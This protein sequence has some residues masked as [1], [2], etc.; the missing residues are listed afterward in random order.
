MMSDD[1]KKLLTINNGSTGRKD[2]SGAPLPLCG[3]TEQTILEPNPN[4]EPIRQSPQEQCSDRLGEPTPFKSFP[5]GSLIETVRDPQRRDGFRLVAYKDQK[6]QVV[7]QFEHNGDRFV[8]GEIV[9]NLA[10]HLRLA[11]GISL[12]GTPRDLLA[13]LVATFRDFVDLPDGVLQIF[14]AFVL[15]TWFP[16]RLR[17]A[18]YL[19]LVGPL[20]SGKTTIEKLLQALCRRAFLVGDLTPASLYQLPGLLSPTLLI[21]ENDLGDSLTSDAIRRLLRVGNTPGTP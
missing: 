13:E 6:T 8:P 11:A 19:W 4:P 7:D 21:D 5:D 16:D 17:V 10:P 15:C 12:C 2:P 20:A 18:P 14:G 9:R 1:K 3:T